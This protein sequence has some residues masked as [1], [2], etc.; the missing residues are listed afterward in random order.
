MMATQCMLSPPAERPATF[1]ILCFIRLAGG[2]AA[3]ELLSITTD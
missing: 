2:G 1:V 3:D